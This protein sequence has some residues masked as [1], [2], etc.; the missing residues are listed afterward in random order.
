MCHVRSQETN[1]GAGREATKAPSPAVQ[2]VPRTESLGQGARQPRRKKQGG[3]LAQEGGLGGPGGS[4]LPQQG[5][6]CKAHLLR[7]ESKALTSLHRPSQLC[8]E[9]S[10]RVWR[11]VNHY[12]S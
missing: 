6:A 12:I 9:H 3:E 11:G 8:K 7:E 4:E 5:L 10:Q 1:H 2:G